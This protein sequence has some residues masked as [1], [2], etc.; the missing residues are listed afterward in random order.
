MKQGCSDISDCRAC[1]L[2]PMVP[3]K[4]FNNWLLPPLRRKKRKR[5]KEILFCN[6]RSF[7]PC[8]YFHYYQFQDTNVIAHGCQKRCSQWAI[9]SQYELAPAHHHLDL[10][11]LCFLFVLV[12]CLLLKTCTVLRIKQVLKKILVKKCINPFIFIN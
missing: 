2:Y 4:T 3:Q 7:L 9:V 12:L 10:H 6:T 1:I 11:G 5:R 8:S